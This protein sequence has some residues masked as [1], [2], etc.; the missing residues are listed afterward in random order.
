MAG[1]MYQKS[2]IHREAHWVK[3]YAKWGA[4]HGAHI[5][6]HSDKNQTGIPDTSTGLEG[7]DYWIEWKLQK[8]KPNGKPRAT[9]LR[10]YTLKQHE[11]LTER[12]K[13]NGDRCYIGAVA[14]GEEYGNF[15]GFWLVPAHMFTFTEKNN[16]TLI[17]GVAVLHLAELFNVGLIFNYLKRTK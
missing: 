4:G 2:L 7:H 3:E 13:R 11:W 8:I 16:D 12:G 9:L 14:E 17:K 6:V 5:Q 1:V 10:H 15:K